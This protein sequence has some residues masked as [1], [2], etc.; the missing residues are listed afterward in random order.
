MVR[1]LLHANIEAL[2]QKRLRLRVLLV[3]EQ[4]AADDRERAGPVLVNLHQRSDHLGGLVR[5]PRA[6][7]SRGEALD[8]LAGAR[9]LVAPDTANVHQETPLH[10]DLAIGVPRESKR[11]CEVPQRG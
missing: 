3:V 4:D 8:C 1:D 10:R 2:A 6:Q 7:E 5:L 11:E 9:V